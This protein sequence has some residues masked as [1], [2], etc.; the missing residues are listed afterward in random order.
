M[1]IGRSEKQGCRGHVTAWKT[2]RA[3]SA[4]AAAA[5]SWHVSLWVERLLAI[6]CIILVMYHVRLVLTS[7]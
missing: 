7:S 4:A 2:T 1:R 3:L 6:H 5:S